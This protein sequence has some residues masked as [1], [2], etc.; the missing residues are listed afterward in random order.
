MKKIRLTEKNLQNLIGKVVKFGVNVV[1]TKDVMVLGVGVTL[2]TVHV[3]E[4]YLTHMTISLHL[5][6]WGECNQEDK[7]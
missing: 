2:W 1:K 4:N 5:V 3:A 6:T 7:Y